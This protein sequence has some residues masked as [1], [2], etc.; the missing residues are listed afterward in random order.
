MELQGV[1]Q[2]TLPEASTVMPAVVRNE[3]RRPV[4]QPVNGKGSACDAS[5]PTDGDAA[6]ADLRRASEIRAATAYPA[7]CLSGSRCRMSSKT[8]R[9]SPKR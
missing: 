4:R 1:V 7:R 3:V 2:S 6:M 5:G 9:A 8:T